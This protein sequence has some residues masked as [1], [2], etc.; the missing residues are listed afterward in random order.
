MLLKIN[1]YRYPAAVVGRKKQP[2][3]SGSWNS[4]FCSDATSKSVERWGWLL[5]TMLR[6]CWRKG[7][8]AIIIAAFLWKWTFIIR[9]LI[10]APMT[11]RVAFLKRNPVKTKRGIISP[12]M[13]FTMKEVPSMHSKLLGPLQWIKKLWHTSRKARGNDMNRYLY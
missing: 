10:R 6:W 3:N 11:E 5:T 2:T 13:L 7:H 8:T 12:C 4:T 1:A 9:E